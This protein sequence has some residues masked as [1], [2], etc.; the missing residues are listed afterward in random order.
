[1]YAGFVRSSSVV[2]TASFCFGEPLLVVV[3]AHV[4]VVDR[5]ERGAS[6]RAGTR[7]AP[8]ASAARRVR[9]EDARVER[10]GEERVVDA[11]EHVADRVVLGEDRLVE[12]RARVAGLQDLH[13]DAGLLRERGEHR[14][15]TAN[16][17]WVT[18]VIVVVDAAAAG[19]ASPQ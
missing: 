14:F 1:M 17:S 18:S 13:L 16:E 6:G 2:G 9:L 8:S 5:R 10:A 15:E 19:A 11:E 7:R 12:R 4:A 3:D